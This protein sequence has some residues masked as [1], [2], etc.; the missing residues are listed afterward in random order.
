M[1]DSF[2][3]ELELPRGKGF[4]STYRL[5]LHNA[6]HADPRTTLT[7]VRNRDRL[8]KSPAYVLKY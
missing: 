7:Y 2:V 6:G 4:H 5:T 1:Q 8:S 3:A